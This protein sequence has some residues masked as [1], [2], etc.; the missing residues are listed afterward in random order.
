MHFTRGTVLLLLALVMPAWYSSSTGKYGKTKREFQRL[1]R[2]KHELNSTWPSFINDSS[3]IY[4]LGLFIK[5]RIPISKHLQTSAEPAMFRAAILL[6]QKYN[7]TVNG[8][9]F[10]YRIEDTSGLDVIETLDRTCLA[11]SENHVLGIVW[12]ES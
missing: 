7:I 9:R 4:L 10:A 8:K 11:I 1:Q 2:Q 3:Y 5:Q 6:S 12:W